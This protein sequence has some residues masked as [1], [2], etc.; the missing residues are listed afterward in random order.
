M[1]KRTVVALILAPILVLL[2]LFA[3][4]IYTALVCGLFCSFAAYELLYGTGLVRHGRMLAYTMA[5][6]FLVALW[7]YFDCP[8]FAAVLGVLIFYVLL[9]GE[10][11][12]S[13]LEIPF[14]KTAMCFA[15]GV[16]IPFLF[17]GLIRILGMGYGRYFIMIPFVAAFMPDIGAYFI[18]VF[19]GKHKL[20]PKI[21]PKKTVEGLIGGLA[22]GVLGMVGY[23]AILQYCFSLSVNYIFMATIGLVSALFS[24]FGDLSFSVVKRQTGIKDYGKLF[25]GHGG[26][27][28]R[29]D[30]VIIV[31]PLIEV[32][33]EL[34]PAV[35]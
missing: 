13:G 28:D 3:P 15:G 21:S 33:L 18:G 2:V 26:I 23:A 35:M 8:R 4:K 31:T 25:P 12:V 9:F 1:L 14:S 7:S 17:C 16:I 22:F 30:S 5:M 24:V 11:M 19:F 27:L 6:A 10:M 34:L 29:F 32:M 20:C